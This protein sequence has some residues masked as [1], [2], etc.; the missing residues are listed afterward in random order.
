[1]GRQTNQETRNTR[2]YSCAFSRPP[3]TCFTPKPDPLKPAVCPHPPYVLCS[4]NQT[5]RPSLQSKQTGP[6]CETRTSRHSSRAAR[7]AG[8]VATT[9]SSEHVTS[10]RSTPAGGTSPD[11][12]A[13]CRTSETDSSLLPPSIPPMVTIVLMVLAVVCTGR[14]TMLTDLS[15]A[16][17]EECG[18]A[19]SMDDCGCCSL[20]GGGLFCEGASNCCV[21]CVASRPSVSFLSRL[22]MDSNERLPPPPF[23]LPWRSSSAAEAAASW[24]PAA[25]AVCRLGGCLAACGGGGLVGAPEVRRFAAWGGRG[26]AFDLVGTAAV[27][28]PAPGGGGGCE[29][30]RGWGG[31]LTAGKDCCCAAAAAAVA[32]AAAA[33]PAAPLCAPAPASAAGA[34][35]RAAL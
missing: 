25:C 22:N 29:R 7:A 17:E 27:S 14:V 19:R 33:A 21:E 13:S 35:A 3:S 5:M 10:C 4:A 15:A 24:P 26:G 12:A 6:P 18:G 31:C 23:E 11:S 28:L 8:W 16:E 34:A 32:V 9:P 30:T 20:G 2:V 1:M